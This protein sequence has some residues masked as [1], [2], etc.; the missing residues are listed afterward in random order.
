M[1]SSL[2]KGLLLFLTGLWVRQGGFNHKMQ[3]FKSRL[4]TWTGR[5]IF[6]LLLLLGVDLQMSSKTWGVYWGLSSFW[7]PD[8]HFSSP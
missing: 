2:R 1:L 7:G 3:L 8:V 4:H 6:A 5:F